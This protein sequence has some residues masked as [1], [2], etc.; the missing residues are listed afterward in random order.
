MNTGE[1]VSESADHSSRR[2]VS[3]GLVVLASL[4]TV[5]AGVAFWLNATLLDTDTF[6]ETVNPVLAEEEVTDAMGEVLTEQT[7]S[8]LGVEERV[9]SSLARTDA[10]LDEWV[11]GLV[12]FAPRIEQ[13]LASIDR[14]RFTDLA[15]PLVSA[16]QDSV[17]GAVQEFLASDAFQSAF[18]AAVIRA[19]SSAVALLREE[20]DQLPAVVIDRGAVTLDLT[21]AIVG[22]IQNLGAG[23]VGFVGFEPPPA[24]AAPVETPDQARAWMSEVLRFDPS[25][26]FA[27]ITIMTA[28]TLEDL[29]GAVRLLE[30]LGLL[31]VVLVAVLAIGAVVL[32]P[33]RT[34]TTIQLGVGIALATL[35]AGLAIDRVQQAVVEAVGDPAQR[36]AARIVLAQTLSGLWSLGILVLA[37]A[38]LL[39]LGSLAT[40]R[41]WHRSAR[42]WLS[43]E[44]G[45]S[46]LGRFVQH[47]ADALR[48]AAAALA[49]LVVWLV[50]VSTWSVVLAAV[51]LGSFL[52]ALSVVRSRSPDLSRAGPPS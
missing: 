31:L 1:G 19:H 11:L 16:A 48:L 17:E 26:E 42:A 5:I 3:A 30:L 20:Y 32:S 47:H 12:E 37:C 41:G 44:S 18:R 2:L 43:S 52:F 39:A 33:H 36:E 49:L 25:P 24:L 15:A 7:F 4:A 29:Q 35:A 23:G 45:P 22:V 21:P 28:D 27:Q 50:G 38:F 9:Y 14:P 13:R 51:V 34:R 8:A 10:F 40:S 6:T 46:E